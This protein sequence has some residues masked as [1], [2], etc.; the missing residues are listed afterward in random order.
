MATIQ[1][2]NRGV[3]ETRAP[4]TFER[5]NITPEE[6]GAGVGSALSQVAGQTQAL[7]NQLFTAE[8]KEQL[9]IDNSTTRDVLNK[10]R[11]ADSIFMNSIFQKKGSSAKNINKEVKDYFEKQKNTLPKELDN[12]RQKDKFADVYDNFIIQNSA[13]ARTHHSREMVNYEKTSISSQQDNAIEEGVQYRNNTERMM[14]ARTEVK[15]TSLE[16]TEDLPPETQEKALREDTTRFDARVINGYISDENIDTARSYFNHVKKDMNSEVRDKIE[17]ALKHAGTKKE[18]QIQADKIVVN[19]DDFETQLKK[20]RSIKNADLRDATVT[21]IK[22]RHQEEN[23][24]KREARTKLVDS[25]ITDI[26]NSRSPEQALDIANSLDALSYDGKGEDRAKLI[27]FATALNKKSPNKTTNPSL[28]NNSRIKIDQGEY[29]SEGEIIAELKGTASDPDLR[30]VIK[31]FR[32]G[33]A[34]GSVSEPMVRRHFATISGLKIDDDPDLYNA[35]WNYA[36]DNVKDGVKPTDKEMRSIVAD[37]LVEGEVE[38]GKW[39]LSD[40]DMSFS[41]ATFQGKLENWFPEVT[42]LEEKSI[43]KIL[44][45]AGKQVNDDTIKRYKK[46]IILG[47]PQ[48]ITDTEPIAPN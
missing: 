19:N 20:A 1:K 12:Q 32:D 24:I 41:E 27:K 10:G 29:Q 44:K 34:K 47:V 8:E 7:G 45:S 2:F 28:V 14:E 23:T 46:H 13:A 43:S 37:A 35:V 38:S 17:V 21:R 40:K 31:Y 5:A 15:I 36:L 9:R 33:G 30:N 39:Y 16:L 18:S 42:D 11:S 25:K 6:L 48:P 26:L 4:V 3:A 22:A